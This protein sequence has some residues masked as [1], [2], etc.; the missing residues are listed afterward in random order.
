MVGFLDDGNPFAAI[1]IV[2]V[3]V[4]LVVLLVVAVVP[5]NVLALE[6]V[7]A[8]VLLA[9]GVLAR[10]VLRKPWIVEAAVPGTAQR[11]A[12]KVVGWRASGRVVDE[13]A[14]AL[15]SGVRHLSPP[16]AAGVTRPEDMGTVRWS[17]PF[18]PERR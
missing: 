3:A 17:A 13:V 14:R 2:F 11:Q 1:L 16:G 8:L 10:F 12:W 6:A 4:L 5:V 15:E 18:E 7:L 9:G